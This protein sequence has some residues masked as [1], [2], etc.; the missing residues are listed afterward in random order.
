MKFDQ[1]IQPAGQS[2]I[3]ASK[4]SQVPKCETRTD[5]SATPA[6][7]R[8]WKNKPRA[9]T[10]FRTKFGLVIPME[11]NGKFLWCWKRTLIAQ[12]ELNRRAVESLLKCPRHL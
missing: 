11:T 12:P 10:P 6:L 2:H 8:Q 5:G 7:R 3:T 1:I 9:A 4:S